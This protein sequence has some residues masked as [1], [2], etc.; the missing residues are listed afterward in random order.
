M[1]T[2]ASG[3]GGRSVLLIEDDPDDA[4]VVLHAIGQHPGI[5]LEHV[6]TGGEALDA[7]DRKKYDICL[8][9]QRLPDINGVELISKIIAAGHESEIIMVSGVREDTIVGK[10]FAAGATDFIVKDMDYGEEICQHIGVQVS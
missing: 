1:M 2:N 8:V 6:R 10:A 9:D 4:R 5:H 7:L 3:A